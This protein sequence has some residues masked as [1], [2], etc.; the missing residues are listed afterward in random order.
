[1]IRAVPTVKEL[2]RDASRRLKESD[3][4]DHPHGGKEVADAEEILTHI[5]GR[6]P[7]PGDEISGPALAKFRRLL[8]ATFDEVLLTR[9]VWANLPPAI[10]Y[11]C[12]RAR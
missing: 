7:R 2:Y 1:M 10:T 12:R 8:E 3:A 4:V 9:V 6:E 11:V 5:L